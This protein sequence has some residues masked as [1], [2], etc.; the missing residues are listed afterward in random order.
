MLQIK[1]YVHESK[2]NKKHV[3]LIYK[4]FPPPPTVTRVSPLI[5]PLFCFNQIKE[6]DL[7]IIELRR[8]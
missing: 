2:F 1:F 6:F 3:M 5:E 8:L 7:I 4:R